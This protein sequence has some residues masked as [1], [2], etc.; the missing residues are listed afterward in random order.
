MK[1]CKFPGCT[2][3]TLARGYCTGHYQQW[4]YGKTPHPLRRY[5]T[6][7][8]DDLKAMT[9]TNDNGC[10]IVNGNSRLNMTVSVADRRIPL[11]RLA[12]RLAFGDEGNCSWMDNVCGNPYCYNPDHLIPHVASKSSK[13]SSRP[14]KRYQGN[15]NDPITREGAIRFWTNIQRRSY[16]CWEWTGSLRCGYGVF[17]YGGQLY[18]AHR[19]AYRLANGFIPDNLIIDHICRNRKCVNP[20]HLRLGTYALNRQNVA[21]ST[22]SR[23]GHLNVSW[24]KKDNRWEV[25]VMRNGKNFYGGEYRSLSDAVAAARKLRNKVSTFNAIDRYPGNINMETILSE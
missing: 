16:G 20:N 25:S 11:K 8:L 13:R 17:G 2:K 1:Q 23:S 10:F 14:R 3:K 6:F 5:A 22:K 24:K 19:F 7:D 12:Y 18:S 9:T 21:E 15:I 4:Y